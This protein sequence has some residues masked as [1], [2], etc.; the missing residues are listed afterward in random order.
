MPDKRAVENDTSPPESDRPPPRFTSDLSG[1]THRALTEEMTIRP[2][3][4]GRYVI[5]TAGGTYVVDFE[6]PSCTCPDHAISGEYCKH[7]RRVSF[8]I[9]AESIPAPDQRSGACAVCGRTIF[10]PR[11]QSGSYLCDAHR[12]EI[13]EI[14]RDRETE[15]LLVVVAVT[16]DR[17]D[18]YETDEGRLVAEYATNREYGDHEPVIRAVYAGGLAP[19]RDTSDLRT[20]SFPASR[21]VRLDRDQ[22]GPSIAV[23]QEPE[24]PST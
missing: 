9:A 14:V 8:E 12:P 5:E 1:R 10:V 2:L 22:R 13:G 7:L 16:T 18:Q 17:A 19:D 4:D 11:T 20:Y 24:S 15:E 6:V 3:R 21:I 23:P